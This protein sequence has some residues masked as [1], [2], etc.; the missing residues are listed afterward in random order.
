VTDREKYLQISPYDGDEG[1]K[2]GLHPRSVPA[3]DLLALGHPI[4]P[5]K[6]IRAKCLDCVGQ[7]ASEVRKCTA[8]DCALWPMRMGS[9]P[10]H[11]RAKGAA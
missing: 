6:A 3:S 11:A 10:F 5:I 1:E 2:V 8:V 7:N 9:N 4:S